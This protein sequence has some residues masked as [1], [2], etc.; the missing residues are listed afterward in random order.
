MRLVGAHL[1]YSL[2]VCLCAP[3]HVKCPTTLSPL[4]GFH[5]LLTLLAVV[6]GKGTYSQSLNTVPNGDKEAGFLR[7][8]Q[9]RNATTT[10]QKSEWAGCTIGQAQEERSGGSPAPGEEISGLQHERESPFEGQRT[11]GRGRR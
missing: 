1:P 3:F 9:A 4:G 11:G 10:G 6:I 7:R 5:S 8:K 2:L